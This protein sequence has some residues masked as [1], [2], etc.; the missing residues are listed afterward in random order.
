MKRCYKGVAMKRSSFISL[1]IVTNISFV[2]LHIH[3]QSHLIKLSY[4]K[5]KIELEKQTLAKLKQTLTNQ[6][7]S[8]HDRAQV[9]KFVQDHPNLQLKPIKIGQIKKIQHDSNI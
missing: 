6:L 2:L 7:Y 8:L 1:F 3:K 4:S 5:Q 9:K